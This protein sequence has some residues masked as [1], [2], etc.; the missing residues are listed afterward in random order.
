M[1]S[2]MNKFTKEEFLK[3]YEVNEDILSESVVDFLDRLFPMKFQKLSYSGYQNYISLV[4][5]ILNKSSYEENFDMN[6][7][8]VFENLKTGKIVQNREDILKPIWFR[9]DAYYT[10]D[11]VPCTTNIENLDWKNQIAVRQILFSKYLYNVDN[12]YDFG[13]GSGI[14]IFLINEIYNNINYFASDNSKVSLNILSE[15]KSFLNCNLKVDKIDLTKKIN[16]EIKS[17]SAFIT[18]SSLEQVGT[19]IDSFINLVLEK[20]PN[21]VINIE[22]ILEFC[23]DSPFDNLMKLYC[24][25]RKYLKYYYTKLLSLE[26]QNKIEILFKKKTKISGLFIEN[27]VIIWRPISE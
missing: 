19:N 13:S 15:L 26:K 9:N 24:E 25:K 1:S 16:L 20:K 2:F 22:P 12:V 14:N 6:W 27:S 18:T 11:S 7:S 5:S 3:Y 23:D 4:F 10:I 21:V 8:Y 17:N